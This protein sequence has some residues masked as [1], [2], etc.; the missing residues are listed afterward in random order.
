M[1]ISVPIKRKSVGGSEGAILRLL[2]VQ[3]ASKRPSASG[4]GIQEQGK[5]TPDLARSIADALATLSGIARF[6]GVERTIHTRLA[7]CDGHVYLDL[8]DSQ[9][10]KA[11]ADS[12]RKAIGFHHE[13]GT[14]Y[15]RPLQHLEQ[16]VGRGLPSQR[17][18]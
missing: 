1:K 14:Q 13:L 15:L 12:A 8:G 2:F 10:A 6:D 17:H 9:R 7:G 16:R 11:L 18:A 4:L 5:L 3:L